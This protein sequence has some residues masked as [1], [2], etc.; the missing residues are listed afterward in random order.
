MRRRIPALA[1][2]TIGIALALIGLTAAPS[3]A[4]EEDP[5][6]TIVQ[7]DNAVTCAPDDKDTISFPGSTQVGA[8]NDGDSADANVSGVADGQFLD[9]TILNPDVVIDGIIV[10]GGN[11][12]NVYGPE[13]APFTD[14]RA[15]LVGEG[16]IPD[17]SHWF[18]CYHLVESDPETVDVTLDKVTTGGTAPAASAEFTFTVVCESGTATSPVTI[19]PGQD[20]VVV[21]EDV[22]E[23]DSCT[24][25]ETNAAG[26][27]STAFQVS[28]GT[29]DTTTANSVTFSAGADV[30]VVATNTYPETTTT[31]SSTTSTT[32]AV[33]SSVVTNTTTTTAAAAQ[34]A[35]V[36]LART[37]SP[38]DFWYLLAG[39]AFLL[40]GLCLGAS[41][42]RR[43]HTRR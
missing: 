15:P 35:G 12:Y 25:T 38:A 30:A 39:G 17:I 37:G 8:N 26:A 43:L 13:D 32:V 20:P 42:N 9:V 14:L 3:T 41:T 36:Q 6:A 34:V 27:T 5:R 40:G 23:D 24:I 29:V 28:G 18:I 4:A 11:A 22:T 31:T 2:I 19:T 7:S 21:A 16:N 33:Q 10:K 1:F